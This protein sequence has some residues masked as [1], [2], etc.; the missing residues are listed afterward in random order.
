MTAALN[1]TARITRIALFAAVGTSLFVVESFI[2]M[3]FPF[4]KIGLANVSTLLALYTLGPAAML[5]VVI[6]RVVAGS[7]LLGSVFGP[8][9]I[10]AI[11]AGTVSASVMALSK[12]LFSRA[13]SAFGVGLIGS[14]AHVLTQLSAVFILYV[15]NESVFLLLPLLL[16][17]AL[18]GGA[19]VGWISVRL[20]AAMRRWNPAQVC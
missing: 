12:Q 17:S 16:L 3:P 2:P 7:L 11:S 4:L 9:F 13:L 10:L 5:I 8:A 19:I 20:L 6:V 18:V 15:R 14:F 1:P